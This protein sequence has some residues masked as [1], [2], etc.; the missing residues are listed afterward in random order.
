MY[1]VFV[2]AVGGTSQNLS[3]FSLEVCGAEVRGLWGAFVQKEAETESP[4]ARYTENNPYEEIVIQHLKRFESQVH[5]AFCWSAL[6]LHG[7]TPESFKL[8]MIVKAG[9]FQFRDLYGPRFLFLCPPNEFG[10]PKFT[11]TFIT[12]V[13][14][15]FP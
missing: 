15:P 14:L 2:V 11:P 13:I 10:C 4:P 1:T 8:K 7:V 5:P 12:P 6:Q 3:W 9:C